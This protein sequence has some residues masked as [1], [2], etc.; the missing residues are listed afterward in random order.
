[1][2]KVSKI[3][4]SNS[5]FHKDGTGAQVQRI[6][7]LVAYS[8]RFNLGFDLEPVDF[9]EI[10]HGD[11][12]NSEN[13]IVD[14]LLRLNRKINDVLNLQNTFSKKELATFR[15]LKLKSNVYNLFVRIPIL[16]VIS[17][18]FNLAIRIS[19]SDAYPFTSRFPDTYYSIKKV[20]LV[21]R[22][23]ADFFFDVQ[24]HLRHSTLSEKSNRHV[25][26][27]FFLGW[28]NYIN[29]TARN[30]KLSIRLLIHTDCELSN[31]NPGLV[32][33]HL[34][35]E[36][37]N[38]WNS[39]GV[40]D[41]SGQLDLT[42]ISL[43]KDLITKI[44]AIFPNYEIIYGLD[45]VQAWSVMAQSDVILTSKS[46]FSFIG[47]LLSNDAIIIAPE[48]EMACPSDWIVGEYNFGQNSDTFFRLL[49][50]K[51]FS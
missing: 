10:Q 35:P 44:E 48:L 25:S 37:E 1:L 32:S 7:S 49:S 38:Y 31:Y 47:A 12:F 24:V 33:S 51:D 50:N 40:T 28:L 14:F 19:L 43:Y 41:D 29:E 18:V 8:N 20:E 22:L 9:I 13:E 39:I 3:V 2:N 46:S 5:N 27:D 30:A 23:K 15:H 45:P 26:S 21:S 36:T 11:G 6:F 17:K 34:T 42:T 4:I 16:N